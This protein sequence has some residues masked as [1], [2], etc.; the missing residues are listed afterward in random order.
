MLIDRDAS[1][2]LDI[3]IEPAGKTDENSF[4]ED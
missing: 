1:G 3:C 2:M 4:L